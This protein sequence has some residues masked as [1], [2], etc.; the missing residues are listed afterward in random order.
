MP[1]TPQETDPIVARLNP[2]IALK[3]EDAILTSTTLLLINSLIF[4]VVGGCASKWFTTLYVGALAGVCSVFTSGLILLLHKCHNQWR[5]TL[6]ENL[7]H[8]VYP[9]SS[10]I[11]SIIIQ[12]LVTILW[13]IS[14]LITIA[15]HAGVHTGTLNSDGHPTGPLSSWAELAFAA[16]CA[17]SS[18]ML[19]IFQI[20]QRRSVGNEIKKALLGKAAI[21]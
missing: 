1:S 17:L 18:T 20:L 11:T 10:T 16:V 6:Y 2:G 8:G 15:Y 4:L 21:C 7:V 9:P 14:S 12:F 5:H 3:Y 13:F 19:V